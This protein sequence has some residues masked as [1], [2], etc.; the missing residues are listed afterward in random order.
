MGNI[1]LTCY[2]RPT[3]V[4]KHAIPI[5]KEKRD[6]KACAQIG[7]GKTAAFLLPIL[8]Q[9][10]GDGPGEALEAVKENGRYGCR[11]QYPLSLVL[12]PTRELAVQLMRKPEN[13]HTGLEVVLVWFIVVL[14]LVSRFEI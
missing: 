13:F 5:I 11:K 14:I 4:Q 10:Y 9:I 7:S 3:P 1:E 2:T 6:L 8:S 12:A